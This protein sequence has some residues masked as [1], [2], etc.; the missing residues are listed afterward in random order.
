MMPTTREREKRDAAWF[1]EGRRRALGD[2]G[3]FSNVIITLQEK[4]REE[5]KRR[6]EEKEKVATIGE[7][8]PKR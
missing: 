7:R 2:K 5:E 6:G 4:R 1:L 3:L 8:E